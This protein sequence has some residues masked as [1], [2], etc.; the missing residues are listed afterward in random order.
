MSEG[1][2][3][4]SFQERLWRMFNVQF[5]HALT[6]PQVDRIRWHMFPDAGFRVIGP[7]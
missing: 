5:S 2:E 3:A 7:T 1:V 6:M 4:E